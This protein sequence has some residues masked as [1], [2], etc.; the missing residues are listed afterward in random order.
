MRLQS[1]AWLCAAGLW[2]ALPC[3]VIAD[4][5][6]H[7]GNPQLSGFSTMSATALPKEEWSFSAGKPVKGGAAIGAGRVY[8]GDDAGNVHA[9]RLDSGGKEWSFKTDGPVE[10]TPLLL[11]GL[12]LVGS[13]DGKLYALEAATGVKRWE[14]E[15][16]DKIMGGANTAKSP[17]GKADWVFVGSYDALLHCVDAS[18]GKVVWTLS[19]DNYINGTPALLPG[20]ELIFGGCD[21]QLRIV[22]S[23]DGKQL[24]EI[25]AEAYVASSVAVAPDG[26]AYVG[27]Y[28]NLVLGLDVKEAKVSWRYR[29]RNFPYISSAA[30][31]GERVFIGGGDKRLHCI[32]RTTGKGIWQFATR[33][34][35]DGSPVVC[36][37]T[38]VVG[39]ADGRLYGV[40]VEDGSERWALDLGAPVS[41]S[42][43]VSDG[44]I[45]V[46]TEDG[47]VHGFRQPLKKS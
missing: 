31:A 21:A 38:V 36:D 32:E 6:M 9:L 7:R 30:V 12:V 24:R 35:V 20:G 43:A 15:T 5:P 33:G 44:W 2:T 18:T 4:W 37:Q 23:A 10:A 26:G 14:Y 28:G 16:G 25:E 41:A 11:G 40:A 46:G 39:S 3:E 42:P 29:D 34:K 1:L 17:D 22:S 27:H 47:V 13:G 45:I 19:T 8:V